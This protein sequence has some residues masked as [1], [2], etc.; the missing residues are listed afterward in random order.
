MKQMRL[1][2]S[3]NNYEKTVDEKPKYDSRSAAKE[4]FMRGI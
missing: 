3:Q 1:L 2:K 4:Y